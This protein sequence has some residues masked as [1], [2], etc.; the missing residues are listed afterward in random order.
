MKITRTQLKQLIKEELSLNENDDKAAPWGRREDGTPEHHM[1]DG[2]HD[3]RRIGP[4]GKKV[5]KNVDVFGRIVKDD[6]HSETAAEEAGMAKHLADND[7]QIKLKAAMDILGS[8]LPILDALYRHG[9]GN[10]TQPE[11]QAIL[12][13]HLVAASVEV[14]ASKPWNKSKN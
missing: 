13:R 11:E 10:M 3:N 9:L 5:G 2:T 1:M 8:S 4:D 7:E 12:A 14:M 6:D